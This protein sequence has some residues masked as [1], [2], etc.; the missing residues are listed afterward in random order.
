M[1]STYVSH[2]ISCN[3]CLKCIY[4]SKTYSRVNICNHIKKINDFKNR[5]YNFTRN[6]LLTQ[7]ST[8]YYKSACGNISRTLYIQTKSARCFG[9][10]G[11]SWPFCY[12]SWINYAKEW[13]IQSRNH[14]KKKLRTST[15][16]CNAV[17]T[18]MVEP[19]IYAFAFQTGGILGMFE[20]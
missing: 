7:Y 18:R 8:V 4:K 11:W 10:I 14:N 20:I 15:V 5:I 1:L 16:I 17:S 19:L 12:E 6:V 9:T 3:I 13:M 2:S